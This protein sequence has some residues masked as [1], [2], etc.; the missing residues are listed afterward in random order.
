MARRG[1]SSIGLVRPKDIRNVGAVLRAAFAY[2]SSLVAIEGDRTPVAGPVDTTSAWRHMP[3]IRHND[4]KSIIPHG[5]VPVAIDLVEGAT[6][7]A[8]FEHPERAFYIFGP[9]DGTLG[10]R[11]L[12]FVK[13][14]IMIPTRICMNLAA[15]VNVVLYDRMV[16]RHEY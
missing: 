2:N 5:A 6:N 16:K 4:L 3:V 7:L 9:E 14:A 13:H 1:F 11:H 15:T 8:D 12:S 10:E